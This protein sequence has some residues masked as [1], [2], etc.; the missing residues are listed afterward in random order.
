MNSVSIH[1]RSNWA[2]AEQSNPGHFEQTWHL[3]HTIDT[4]SARSMQLKRSCVSLVLA[5][6][7]HQ[8][9][10]SLRNLLPGMARTNKIAQLPPEILT[11]I[12]SNVGIRQRCRCAQ[13]SK[14]WKA[15]AATATSSIVLLHGRFD[16]IRLQQ[17]GSHLQVLQLHTVYDVRGLQQWLQEHGGHLQVLQLHETD[18]S[19]LPTVLPSQLQHLYLH[20]TSSH[21]DSNVDDMILEGIS[22][23]GTNLKTVSLANIKTSRRP[24]QVMAIFEALPK[25]QH[26]ALRSVK[27]PRWYDP[28]ATSL[29]GFTQ[30]TGLDLENVSAGTLE[31]HLSAL[32]KL[33]HLSLDGVLLRSWGESKFPGLQQLTSLTRL[34]LGNGLGAYNVI[35]LVVVKLTAVQHLRVPQPTYVQ[36]QELHALVG[37]TSLCVQDVVAWDYPPSPLQL[38]ALRRLEFGVHCHSKDN[39][40]PM[41]RLSDCLRLQE[42]SLSRLVLKDP[43]CVLGLTSL[44]Y[45][46]TPGVFVEGPLLKAADVKRLVA[47]CSSLRRLQLGVKDNVS[48][49]AL[50]QLPHL[51]HLRVDNVNEWYTSSLAQLTGLRQL[52]A[53]YGWT[54]TP[55]DLL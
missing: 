2:A 50:S 46:R 38:T 9:Q 17:H 41:S 5:S 37:L 4:V 20:Q 22:A 23:S 32:T 55:K 3:S 29:Q 8:L 48:L 30:L 52:V 13:V 43:R 12:L 44:Q 21:F 25:L 6:V 42:L 14:T 26:L 16:N 49:S 51:T 15:A 53:G 39:N 36:V 10:S 35:P 1:S 18:H 27:Y 40:M 7:S 33:R 19:S 28:G 11:K 45:A 24:E 34:H 47:C 31:K 54:P